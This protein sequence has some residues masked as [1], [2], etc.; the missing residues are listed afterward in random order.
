MISPEAQQPC[1]QPATHTV[2]TKPSIVLDTERSFVQKLNQR[3]HLLCLAGNNLELAGFG[4]QKMSTNKWQNCASAWFY[5]PTR[6]TAVTL[7]TTARTGLKSLSK[8]I[9]R[10]CS[11]KGLDD[12]SNVLTRCSSKVLTSYLKRCCIAEQQSHQCPVW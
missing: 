8:K 1:H 9:G 7:R 3:V 2:Q 4:S 11:N 6:S 5:L 10:A 12:C